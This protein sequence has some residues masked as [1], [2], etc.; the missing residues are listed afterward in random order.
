VTDICHVAIPA[1]ALRAVVVTLKSVSNE[2]TLL[3]MREDLFIL[4]FPP[5]TVR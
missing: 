1:H 5:I 3:L 2:G 4:I